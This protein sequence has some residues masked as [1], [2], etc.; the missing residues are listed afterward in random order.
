[1]FKDKNEGFFENLS[2]AKTDIRQTARLGVGKIGKDGRKFRMWF[3]SHT[4]TFFGWGF[5]GVILD[6]NMDPTRPKQIEK[7]N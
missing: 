4:Q 2:L 5:A 3:G 1:M 7:R 6:L